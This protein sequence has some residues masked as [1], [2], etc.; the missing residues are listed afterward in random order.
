MTMSVELQRALHSVMRKY[1]DTVH[2]VKVIVHPDS[3]QSPPHRG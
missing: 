3:A 1:Q 2:E